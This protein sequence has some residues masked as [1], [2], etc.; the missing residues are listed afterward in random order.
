MNAV[1]IIIMLITEVEIGRSLVIGSNH[2]ILPVLLFSN[3]IFLT[4]SDLQYNH[5]ENAIQDTSIFFFIRIQLYSEL[6]F[7]ILLSAM[8]CHPFLSSI[9]LIFHH[10]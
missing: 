9:F 2:I 3:L 6:I 7:T 1:I 10:V 8:L 5:F 4:A